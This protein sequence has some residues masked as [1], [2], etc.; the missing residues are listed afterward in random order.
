M[1]C[2]RQTRAGCPQQDIDFFGILNMVIS[3][4]EIPRRRPGE[5]LTQLQKNEPKRLKSLRR[6]QNRAP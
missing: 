1:R 5:A 6:A 3:F 4:S 2:G